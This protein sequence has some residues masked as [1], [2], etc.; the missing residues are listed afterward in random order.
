MC[1]FA[2]FIASD[3]ANRIDLIETAR[4]MGDALAHRGPD[5]SGVWADPSAAVALAFRR[6]SILD[7]SPAG[8]QPM[9]SADGRYTMVFNGEIYNF[10]EL[11]KDLEKNSG[12]PEWRGHSDTE[13]LLAAI[14]ARGLSAALEQSIGM[15][16]LALWDRRDRT[17]HL[18]RDRIGEKP[19]YYGWAGRTFVFGSELKALRAHP[20]WN[21]EVDR[22]AIAL[23]MRHNCIP[24]PY[25]IYRGISK[26]LPGHILTLASQSRDPVSKPYWSARAAAALGSS[27]PFSDS[28]EA[29]TSALDL[30]LRDAVKKQM[31]AD[32][33]LGAFLSGGIDSSTI[34]A[35]MQAQSPR[36]VKTFTIGFE[37]QGYNE[38]VHAAAIARHLGTDHT[39]LYVTPHQAREV[40]PKLHTIYDEPFADSS[41]IP[42]FLVAQLARSQVTV[43]L[44]G[45]GGDELFGGYTRYAFGEQLWGKLSLFPLSI[46]R[47]IAAALKSLSVE[48]WNMIVKPVLAV[49]PKRYRVGL[50]GDK[51]HKLADVLTHDT[52]HSLY[53]DLVSHWRMPLEIVQTESEP[54]TALDYAND[55]IDDPVAR[56]MLLDLVTYLPDDILTK[57]DRAAMS[58][59]LETRMPLLDHRVVEFA[60]K[61]PLGANLNRAGTKGI[62][63][64]VLYRYV[65]RELVERPKMG[66]GVPI[67]SWLRGPLREWASDLLDPTRLRREGYLKPEL[68]QQRWQEHQSG[69]RNWH[70]PLWDV[71]MF[72][73]WLQG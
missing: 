17:L 52:V 65:P 5:D 70:Y 2:G 68:I 31:V 67:D 27:N 47:A 32:V 62:L 20:H 73:S 56:M 14:A 6:L 69:Q 39:E 45:D 44:S 61:I 21:C 66:F 54:P 41:Q 36:P 11:R 51:A 29:I 15:F 46:R 71:L 37:E 28:N 1:G 24:A 13:V 33:P 18:A 22:G 10:A 57:V 35:L 49:S 50:A 60:W 55:E 16:A 43:A 7:L 40:I 48:H 4:S 72:Q 19:V 38:A 12:A 63:R 58:V 23:L 30:L 59:S 8:H 9:L 25:S 3:G 42:T 34:V 64:N 53:R 26:L